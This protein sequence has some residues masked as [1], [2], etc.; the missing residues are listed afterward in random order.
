MHGEAPPPAKRFKTT[1]PLS[2]A[3]AEAL[4]RDDSLRGA[5]VEAESSFDAWARYGG[6]RK[7]V[8]VV[9]S[10]T[11]TMALYRLKMAQGRALD[12]DDRQA[13]RRVCVVGHEVHDELLARALQ[14]P[15]AGAAATRGLRLEIDGELFAVV[16]VLAEKP[17]LGSTTSTY[18]WDRKVMIPETTY[19]ALYAPAHDVQRIY[20][21]PAGLHA[22]TRAPA[23]AAVLR[24]LHARHL[25]VANFALE[26]D[27]SGGKE[28]LILMVIQVLL[29][30][31]GVL[32]VLASGINIM[33]VMLVTVSERTREIGL[34]RA[35]GAS[36][37]SILV[38][39][40]LEAAALSVVGALVGIVAGI[41]MSWATALLAR[42]AIG[43]WDFA[44]PAWSVLLGL[45]LA[46]VT[47]LGF[48][49]LPAW[50]AARVMPIDA[51][52][53]E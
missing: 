21:R 24:V 53:S 51:L 26:K 36:Q 3:D 27:E 40:L 29:L 32:A 42:A 23:R 11:A 31:T 50:R 12:D 47:G 30:G 35:L 5:K 7:R 2:R 18:R 20:V 39:F 46:L 6:N 49:L 10:G 34:R 25:G 8:A 19:D 4:G 14:R 43:G 45:G 37:R 48:G 9:S 15:G 13:G 44:I 22:A 33:N 17:M 28:R 38:Q 16:G 41:A 52:R 1:R